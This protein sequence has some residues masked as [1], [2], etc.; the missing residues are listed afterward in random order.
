MDPARKRF[1]IMRALT[2]AIAAI[3]RLP[4]DQWAESDRDDMMALLTELEPERADAELFLV[5]GI[6]AGLTDIGRAQQ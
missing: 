5:G 4:A 2:F 1:I 3:D 6:L